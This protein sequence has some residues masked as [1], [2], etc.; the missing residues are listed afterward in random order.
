MVGAGSLLSRMATAS[1]DLKHGGKTGLILADL[2]GQCALTGSCGSRKGS[3]MASVM[4][5]IV[6]AKF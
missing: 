1:L 6:E 5:D 4:K 2:S 3:L